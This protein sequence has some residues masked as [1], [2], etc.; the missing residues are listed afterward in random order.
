MALEL[1]SFHVDNAQLTD[2]PTRLAGGTLLIGREEVGGLLSHKCL[3]RVDLEVVRPGDSMRIVN[4]LDMVQPISAE[5]KAVFPGV[6]GD[7][8]TVGWGT[9]SRLEGFRVVSCGWMPR[10]QVTSLTTK[11]GLID[12]AGPGADLCLGSDTINLV[13]V[14]YPAPGV[15]NDEFDACVRELTLA[16]ARHLAQPTEG[17][18]PDETIRYDLSETYDHLP[19]VVYVNQLQD[20]GPLIR[21]YLYGMPLGEDFVP[22]LIDPLEMMDGAVVSGNYRNCMKKPT[23]LHTRDPVVEEL[24]QA[25][26]RD[27]DFRGVILSRG[28]HADEQMKLRSASYVAKL[29]GL[30]GAEG[31]VLAMEGTGNGTVDFFM[32]MES[33]ERAGIASVGMVHELGG[34]R[35][36]DSALVY[37]NSFADALVSTGGVE[38]ELEL[39][40]MERI[41]G[42]TGF[43]NYSQEAQDPYRGFKARALD[44]YGS[45]WKMS[46]AGLTCVEA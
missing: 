13:A 38:R 20:Q 46:T 28:H 10:T 6:L 35:G 26:G 36:E 25:H 33:C 5:G 41:I 17:R 42:G 43:L 4:V 16:L 27:L 11:D 45:F 30:L 22:T 23:A 40:P 18:E 12:M 2:G 14:Y 15:S 24:C 34:G 44:M 1:C 29:A 31:V 8:R 7:S 3:E 32:T 21:A 19:G 39:P 9:T 37:N